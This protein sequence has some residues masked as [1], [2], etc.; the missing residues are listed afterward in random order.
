MKVIRQ[1]KGLHFSFGGP[2]ESGWLPAGAS[3]PKQQE[4]V[5][6]LSIE[7]GDGG[8]S[9][10]SESSH[11]HFRG[12]DSWHNT[13]ADALAQAESQFGVKASDWKSFTP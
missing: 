3:P 2:A 13:L 9:L 11:P 8:F 5:L 7:E 1:I 12:G 4:T 10:V 6:D